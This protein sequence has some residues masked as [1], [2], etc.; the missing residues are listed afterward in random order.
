MAQMALVGMAVDAVA[1][2]R[3]RPMGLVAC[4]YPVGGGRPLLPTCL[5]ATEILKLTHCRNRYVGGVCCGTGGKSHFP[6]SRLLESWPPAMAV[7]IKYL[8]VLKLDGD[9]VLSRRFKSPV[10]PYRRRRVIRCIYFLAADPEQLQATSDQHRDYRAVCGNPRW[11]I[12]HGFDGP[13]ENRLGHATAIR[14]NHE[15][16]GEVRRVAGLH[17]EPE[18][19]GVNAQNS[20]VAS[21]RRFDKHVS[22]TETLWTKFINDTSFR[23][24]YDFQAVSRAPSFLG[25]WLTSRTHS[26]TYTRENPWLLNSVHCLQWLR[27]PEC[28]IQHIGKEGR[29]RMPGSLSSHLHSGAAPKRLLHCHWIQRIWFRR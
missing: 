25:P 12:R 2:G 1:Y 23:D 7:M 21:I 27:Q 24:I 13:R 17:A 19:R 5:V 4:R 3:P 26:P 14:K 16:I 29:E 15:L 6:E 8:P 11:Y 28:R 22:R 18:W 20:K 9:P 10:L